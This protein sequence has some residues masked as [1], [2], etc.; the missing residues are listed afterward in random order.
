[1]IEIN[2]LETKQKAK[3]FITKL[4]N[5]NFFK[6]YKIENDLIATAEKYDLTYALIIETYTYD[7]DIQTTTD[8]I[9][10]VV[11]KKLKTEKESRQIKL[12][13]DEI[14]NLIKAIRNKNADRMSIYENKIYIEDAYNNILSEITLKQRLNHRRIL[15][16]YRDFKAIKKLF[17]QQIISI[18]DIKNAYLAFRAIS[19]DDDELFSIHVDFD[20]AKCHLYICTCIKK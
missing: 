18:N 16:S 1:M 2:T 6:L 15:I 12:S 10:A 13:C 9:H 14:K 20:F 4:I 19:K 5:D 3:E 17:K 8:K 11:Y 7:I